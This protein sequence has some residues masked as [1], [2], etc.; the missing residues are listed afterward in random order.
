MPCVSELPDLVEV[1]A[2]FE[3]DGGQLLT[4][5]HDLVIDGR[6]IETVRTFAERRGYVFPILVFP[7]DDLDAVVERFDIPGPIPFTLA[8]NADGEVVDTHEGVAGPERL[9][10]MMRAALGKSE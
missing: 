7:G 3:A 9:A 8:V 2:H 5:S 10:E 4:I 6:S 1:A